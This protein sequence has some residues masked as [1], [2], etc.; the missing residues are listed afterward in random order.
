MEDSTENVV[1][2]FPLQSLESLVPPFRLPLRST[3]QGAG[4]RGR[5]FLVQ[6]R[7]DP[8]VSWLPGKGKL[9]KTGSS[10]FAICD[11]PPYCHPLLLGGLVSDPV[12]LQWHSINSALQSDTLRP[13]A[14][15]QC[16]PE[17][18]DASWAHPGEGRA[19]A[20]GWHR[21]PPGASQQMSC[22]R[23]CRGLWSWTG[24]VAK[25][26]SLCN[27]F[28]WGLLADL[29]GFLDIKPVANMEMPTPRWL[30]QTSAR[31]DS[32]HSGEFS[33]SQTSLA[34]AP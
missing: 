27:C 6:F 5:I 4:L 28:F 14:S 11:P 9:P 29:G 22:A 16:S 13:E 2:G 32:S 24:T 3:A 18:G 17:L 25:P 10:R 15:S 1:W 12:I 30:R 23:A 21:C 20:A 26:H 34:K 8:V 33:D 19:L 7:S 31:P